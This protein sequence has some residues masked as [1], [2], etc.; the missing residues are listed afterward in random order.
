MSIE[1][2]SHYSY[3]DLEVF[4]SCSAFRNYVLISPGVFSNDVGGQETKSRLPASRQIYI[5]MFCFSWNITSYIFKIYRFQ[6]SSDSC[7]TSYNIPVNVWEPSCAFTLFYLPRLCEFVFTLLSG[8]Q[9]N[10]RISGFIALALE[11]EKVLE[12]FSIAPYKQH[13]PKRLRGR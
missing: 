6:Y 2:S 7:G 9:S 8:S 11:M 13:V 12:V 3:R 5:Y 1:S 10:L 4:L